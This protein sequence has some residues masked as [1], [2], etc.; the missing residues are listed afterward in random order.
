MILNWQVKYLFEQVLNDWHA[1]TDAEEIKII[2]KYANK[3]RFYTICAGCK[4]KIHY[5]NLRVLVIFILLQL[6]NIYYLSIII[7]CNIITIAYS[8][9]FVKFDEN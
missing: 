3:G 9:T 6:N 4:N 5:A 1:L 7:F 2:R 8:F